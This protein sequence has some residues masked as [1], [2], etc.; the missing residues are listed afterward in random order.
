[1]KYSRILA[2]GGYLPR[3]IMTNAEL[4]KMVNTSDQWIRE[5]TGIR[6]R[7]IAAE[8]ESTCDMAEQAA[9]RAI[10]DAGIE[11]GSIDMIVVATSTPDL[12]YPSTACL[13]QKRL[14]IRNNG[15]AFDI[16]AVCSGFIYALGVID[17]FIRTAS[18]KRALVVGADANSKILDWTDRATCVLFGDGAGAAVVESGTAPGIY[19]TQ[20]CADG[21]YS[22]LLQVPCGVS[23]K[24]GEPF[25]RM[26]GS[27]VFKFAVNAM[28][29]LVDETLSAAGMQRSDIDWLVPHQANE[30]I[31]S[32]TVRKLG[33]PMERV[34][35]TL[36]EHG[37]TSAAS[38]PLALD[39][40]V[41]DG[42]IRRGDVLMLEAVGGGFTWA[43]A[44]LRY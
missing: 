18:V 28:S 26:R 20:L 42:R 21:Y 33:L 22:D 11:S 36:A 23:R 35:L 2:T 10:R 41:R 37:N 19:T 31:I 12:I 1:M 25:V 40:A 34:I 6:S 32:A 4:E 44:L 17:K 5:R 16:Q 15:A 24:E 13:L 7:H 9:R 38:I 27:E 30:R 8:G 39:V 3:R 43:S 29:G 14:G